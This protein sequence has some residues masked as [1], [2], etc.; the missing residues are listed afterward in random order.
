M[1]IRKKKQKKKKTTMFE[2]CKQNKLQ[3]D[4]LLLIFLVLLLLSFFALEHVESALFS[5]A[6]RNFLS[7]SYWCFW[8]SSRFDMSSNEASSTTT[9]WTTRS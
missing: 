6:F 2:N 8:L 1:K 5:C 4:L 7:F 3:S 9:K